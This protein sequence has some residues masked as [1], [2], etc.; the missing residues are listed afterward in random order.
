MELVLLAAVGF[1][2]YWSYKHWDTVG[3]KVKETWEVVKA[4]FKKA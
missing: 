3:P 1:A 4:T 2:V